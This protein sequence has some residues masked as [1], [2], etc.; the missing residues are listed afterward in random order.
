MIRPIKNLS[1]DVIP[2]AILSLPVQ[3]VVREAYVTGNDDFDRYEG[4]SFKLDNEVEIA[5]RHYH[6]H[7][8]D[9]TTIYIDRRQHDIEKITKL[10]RKILNELDVPLDALQWE[11]KDS[12]DL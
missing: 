1:V 12:P 5:V 4:A 7:P 6:G 9:T 3:A 10:I 8:I 11:R 2:Q